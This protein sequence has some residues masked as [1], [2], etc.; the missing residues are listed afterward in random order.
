[1]GDG[2]FVSMRGKAVVSRAALRR[3]DFLFL[4]V[5]EECG[6]FFL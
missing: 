6:L 4:Q 1:M 3:A 5:V 2:I